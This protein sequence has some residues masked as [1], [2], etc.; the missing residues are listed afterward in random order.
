MWEGKR[1]TH[2]AKSACREYTAKVGLGTYDDIFAGVGRGKYETL[3][4]PQAP[5]APLIPI[6][7]DVVVL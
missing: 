4:V 1:Q 5:C 6:R 3:R 7:R 2:L